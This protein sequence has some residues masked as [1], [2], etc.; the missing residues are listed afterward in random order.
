VPLMGENNLYYCSLMLLKVELLQYN[1]TLEVVVLL[2][3]GKISCSCSLILLEDVVLLM[4]DKNSCCC[5]L[6]L[7]DDVVLLMGEKISCYIAV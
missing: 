4:G 2:M 7:L 6:M 1:I 5:S 3:G